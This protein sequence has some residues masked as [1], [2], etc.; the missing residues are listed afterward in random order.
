MI[1][2]PCYAS[3]YR[4]MVEKFVNLHECRGL[5][6]CTLLF[7]HAWTVLSSNDAV[8][9]NKVASGFPVTDNYIYYFNPEY[10]TMLFASTF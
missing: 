2:W 3:T 1:V 10:S 8:L 4:V 6:H 5:Q 9:S 7:L